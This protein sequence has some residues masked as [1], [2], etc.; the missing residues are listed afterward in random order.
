MSET[1][2]LKD[3][4]QVTDEPPPF[5]GRWPRVYAAVLGILGIVIAALYAFMRSFT[6]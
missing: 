6:P 3:I 4:R 5:L 1:S 2:K